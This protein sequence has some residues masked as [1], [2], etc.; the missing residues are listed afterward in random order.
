MAIPGWYGG[1]TVQRNPT[2]SI[3]IHRFPSG[4]LLLLLLLLV[5]SFFSE[6]PSSLPHVNFWIISAVISNA[7]TTAWKSL[8]CGLFVYTII[9]IWFPLSLHCFPRLE[10][11][12]ILFQYLNNSSWLLGNKG[13]V[14][15]MGCVVLLQ[16]KTITKLCN[17]T[18]HFSDWKNLDSTWRF[19]YEISCFNSLG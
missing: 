8:L 2:I 9:F 12:T 1:C 14:E 15:R 3:S 11:S 4:L 16:T 17:P 6:Q 19:F 7:A 5:P 10:D 18:L 13:K